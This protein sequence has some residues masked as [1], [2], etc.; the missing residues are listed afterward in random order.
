MDLGTKHDS[1]E[2]EEEEGLKA[3]EDK[4]DDCR[5]RGEVTALWGR[6]EERVRFNKVTRGEP[7]DVVKIVS[8]I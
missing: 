5:R 8:L 6:E 4:E 2:D 3:Q 1:C 7:K